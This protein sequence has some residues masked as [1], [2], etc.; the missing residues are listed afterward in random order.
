M[1]AVNLIPADAR[2]GQSTGG[3]SG[4]IVYVV[5]GT[6][7][8]LVVLTAAWAVMG[9]QIGDRRDE[10][11][12]L[13]AEA[14]RLEARA[15][16]LKRYEAAAVASK[17]RIDTVKALADSRFEWAHSLREI[18][19]VLPK[20]TWLTSI[21]G[22]TVATSGAAPATGAAT[23]APT[24]PSFEVIGCTRRHDSVARVMAQLRGMDGVT[25]VT[26]GSSQ[27]GGSGGSSSSGGC[28]AGQ[29]E[30]RLT[31]G[32]R[33]PATPATGT[34][35]AAAPATPGA[36]APAAGAPAQS[37]TSTPPANGSAAPAANG[38]APAP[39]TNGTAPAA[40]GTA[41]AG[42]PAPTSPTPG[43]AK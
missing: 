4:G 16:Q 12:Q 10:A 24:G 1:K 38:A 6:L 34:A 37:G 14:T 2:R 30:F 29:P 31:I 11:A 18:S 32:F 41:P 42:Q 27:K 21:N 43:A 22:T 15:T 36:A 23:S 7:A 3:H 39:A 25:G 17:Q 5:L 9:K 13:T 35:G 19:R 40:N 33:G 28:T 26:L 8:V 20:D